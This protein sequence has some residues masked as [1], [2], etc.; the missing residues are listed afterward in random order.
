MLPPNSNNK[1]QTAEVLVQEMGHILRLEHSEHAADIMNAQAHP[2]HHDDLSQI[3][4]TGRDRQMLQWLYAQSNYVPIVPHRKYSDNPPNYG[5]GMPSNEEE[6]QRH[7]A[8]IAI[9]VDIKLK[10]KLISS[11]VHELEQSVLEH[12]LSLVARKSGEI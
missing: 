2:L 5:R 9:L 1:L 10:S 8:R 7:E 4:L 12:K 6:G 11:L 3:K